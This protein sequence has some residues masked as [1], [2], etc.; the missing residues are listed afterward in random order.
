VP[1]INEAFPSKYLKASDLNGAEPVVAIDRVEFEPV[2]RDREMK[3][4][5]YF[6]GK[7]KGLVLN[8]TNATKIIQLTGSG[9]T[10]DWAGFRI[11]LFGTETQ[12]GGDTVDCIRIKAA[13]PNGNGTRAAAKPKPQPEW[14][15]EDH[16]EPVDSDSVP[17]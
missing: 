5:L 14:H 12:Y 7:D 2:G 8:K 1:N 6:K 13:A 17:F 3:A 11:K 15:D 4:V 10:E 16:S 9:M